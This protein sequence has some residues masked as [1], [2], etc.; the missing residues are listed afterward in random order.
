MVAGSANGR[1]GDSG[2]LSPGSNPG[3]AAKISK[4][5]RRY[6]LEVRTGG[7][8]PS[9]RGS[10]PRSAAIIPCQTLDL[11]YIII[12]GANSGLIF[13]LIRIFLFNFHVNNF[14]LFSQG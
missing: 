14:C 7:S 1:P 13:I 12:F 9:D 2:S 3:P 10:I 6:R 11:R 8:Q 5:R 4:N